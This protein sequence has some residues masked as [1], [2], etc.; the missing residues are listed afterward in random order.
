[1][2]LLLACH[3]KVRH[4]CQLS[5]RLLAHVGRHG[6][7][8]AAREAATSVRRYF[9]IAAPLHHADEEEDLFVA[10][11]ALGDAGLQEAMR[12]LA[13]EHDELARMWAGVLPWLDALAEG[14]LPE[15]PTPD[16]DGFAQRYTRHARREE[17]AVYPHA[18]R[19][20]AVAMR[21]LATA[22]VARRTPPHRP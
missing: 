14:R 11:G 17:E 4:F 1:M 2:A 19:L 9:T 3:D 16:V 12:D 6:A 20:S 22:M 15:G 10:L 7:D 18:A 21:E 8:A 13:A 5:Q